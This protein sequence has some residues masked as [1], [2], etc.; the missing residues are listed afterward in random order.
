MKTETYEKL[1]TE[2]IEAYLKEPVLKAEKNKT[3]Q[4]VLV[5][6]LL[7][8]AYAVLSSGV[9]NPNKI[10]WAF[11]TLADNTATLFEE[12]AKLD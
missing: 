6:A 12:E 9:E 8:C 3:P 10:P 11:R 7:R 4:P 2:T 1:V 5:E